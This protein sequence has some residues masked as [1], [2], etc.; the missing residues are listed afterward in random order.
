MTL[1]LLVSLARD[2]RLLHASL[3]YGIVAY[4]GGLP[5]D[6]LQQ[7]RRQASMSTWCNQHLVRCVLAASQGQLWPACS[8]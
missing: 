2:S 8:F 6:A 3:A 7:V 4:G 1:Q 5:L